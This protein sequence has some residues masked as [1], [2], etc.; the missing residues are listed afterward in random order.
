MN[1]S[2]TSI[3]YDKEIRKSLKLLL[4]N[5]EMQ[6]QT[7]LNEQVIDR[8]MCID[9]PIKKNNYK[10]PRTTNDAIKAEKKKLIY[11]PI[12]NKIRESICV[13]TEQANELFKIHCIT[14]ANLI[15]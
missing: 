3:S 10:L 14:V 15:Y 2:N 8:T 9:A 1:I 5:G 6:F 12:L 13:R 4:S 11:A 7:F